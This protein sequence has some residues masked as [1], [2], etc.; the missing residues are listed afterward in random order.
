MT[1]KQAVV[2][3]KLYVYE[4]YVAAKSWV[5]YCGKSRTVAANAVC[6]GDS[7]CIVAISRV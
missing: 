5:V 4:V 6:S 2:G 3:I 7:R 1:A